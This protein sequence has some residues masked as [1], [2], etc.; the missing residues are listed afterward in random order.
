MRHLALLVP[1]ALCA[2]AACGEE[3]PEY[4]HSSA[5]LFDEDWRTQYTRVVTCKESPT[6]NVNH[7]ETW[8]S[9]DALEAYQDRTRTFPL[10]SVVLK[11][12]Y[13]GPGC[14]DQEV[15]F[16][17]MKKLVEEP[18]TELEHWDWQ[19]VE[20]DGSLGYDPVSPGFCGDCH[21]GCN[22]GSFMCD[23]PE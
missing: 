10:G 15:A 11:A 22:Q 9:A 18:A 23:L 16:T 3:L 14:D 13:D 1:V 7:I 17:V 21:T 8:V 5:A 19:R 12:Q 4:T 2:L 6:H 20:A